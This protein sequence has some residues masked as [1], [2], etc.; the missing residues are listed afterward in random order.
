MI[1]VVAAGPVAARVL[2]AVGDGIP[3]SLAARTG[4]GAAHGVLRSF[5]RTVV[6]VI[7]SVWWWYW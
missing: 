4:G 1:V 6:A 2:E 5:T 7:F 3:V